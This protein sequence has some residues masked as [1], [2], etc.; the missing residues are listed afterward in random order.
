MRVLFDVC[1]AR[2]LWCDVVCGCCCAVVFCLVVY[3]RVRVRVFKCVSVVVCDVSCDDVMPCV[4]SVVV[5]L[6]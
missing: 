4:F 5:G 2:N 3:V 6:L 1:D